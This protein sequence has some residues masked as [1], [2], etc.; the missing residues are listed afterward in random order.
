MA[1]T[2]KLPAPWDNSRCLSV[3]LYYFK[4]MAGVIASIILRFIPWYNKFS[5]VADAC[6]HHSIEHYRFNCNL[7][8]YIMHMQCKT[9]L[10]W[11]L[12]LYVKMEKHWPYLHACAYMLVLL[13]WHGRVYWLSSTGG[14][15]SGNCVRDKYLLPCHFYHHTD[16]LT[17]PI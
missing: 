3:E 1:L 5:T 16:R 15:W 14:G 2:V 17:V 13:C 4:L 8:E 6:A 11:S 7:D 10:S 9:H 12:R